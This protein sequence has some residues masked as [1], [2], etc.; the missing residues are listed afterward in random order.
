MGLLPRLEGVTTV[1]FDLNGTLLDD[2]PRTFGGVCA[3][4]QHFGVTP[5][6]EEEWK[7]SISSRYMDLYYKF[8]IPQ[9]VTADEVNAVRNRYT[10]EHWD[11]GRPAPGARD[12]AIYCKKSYQI[13]IITAETGILAH[14]FLDEFGLGQYFRPWVICDASPKRPVLEQFVRSCCRDPKEAVFVDDSHEG[15]KI[16]SQVGM[17][18]IGIVGYTAYNTREHILAA[19]PTAVIE[20]LPEIFFY[21]G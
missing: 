8:G 20:H 14:K 15:I 5:P 4:F 1:I 11:E 17:R 21:L 19:K 7:G 13:A 16:A 9:T 18:T 3:I 2:W 10:I 12:V 6:T